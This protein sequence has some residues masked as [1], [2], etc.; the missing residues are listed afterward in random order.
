MNSSHRHKNSPARLYALITLC[1]GFLLGPAGSAPASTCIGSHYEATPPYL[2]T[3]IKPNV[4]L[5]LDNSGSMKDA[6]YTAAYD[7]TKTYSGI[8]D[9]TKNYKY[10]TTIAVNTTPYSGTP[11][12]V[13]VDTNAKGA[14]LEDS[15]CVLGT[16]TNC[17]KGNFL[18]WL[19]TR[20]IDAARKVLVGGKTESR[21]GY[22]Y[23]GGD[24]SDLEWKIVANNERSDGTISKSNAASYSYTPY[25]N[26]TG[27]SIQSP[28]ENGT[29]QTSY[30]PYAKLVAPT[31]IANS[32]GT[33]IGEAG[34]A[35]S[36]N[37]S[38]KTITLGRTYA[39]PIVVAKPISYDGA[40]P[41]VVRI[42]NVTA[43]SFQVMVKE[44]DYLDQG[45]T[46]E[47]IDYIVLEAGT[48]TLTNGKVRAGA[49]TANSNFATITHNAG[50]TNPPVVISS[51]TTVNEADTVTTRHQNVG[52]NSF[53]L[54][55]QEQQSKGAHGNETVHY[56]AMST[57]TP[58]IGGGTAEVKTV[59]NVTEAWKSVTFTTPASGMLFLAD[60]Q[61]YGDSDPASLRY[62]NLG[63]ASVE[64]FVEE[65]K[66]S[67]T[68]INHGNETVGVI[69]IKPATLNL[70]LIVEAEPTGLV[71]ENANEVRF[72]VSMYRYQRDTDIYNGEWAQGGTMRLPIPYNPFVKDAANTTFRTI[73]TPVKAATATIVDAIEHYPLVWG[74]TPLAENY[75]EVI[76]YFQQATPYYDNLPAIGTEDYL[77]W[78]SS[79]NDPGNLWDPFYYT[80][81][82]SKVRC[83]K[84][85]VIIFTDGEP[86]RDDYIP[87]SFVDYDG[88]LK[89]TDCSNTGNTSNVCP[90]NLDDVAY[91]AYWDKANTRTRDLRSDLSGEQYL[92]TYT[93][94][95]GSA[96]IP[97]ILQDTATNGHGI[98]YAAED[99]DQLADAL[100]AAITDILKKTASGSAIS[101]LSERAASGSVVHQ[102][103]FFPEKTFNT[104]YTLQWPGT[105]NA[106][107]FYNSRTA[108]NIREDNANN[109]FLDTLADNVLD[110]SIDT[111]S[112]NLQI[113]YYGTTSQ[114]AKDTGN[115]IGTYT[116]ID[117]VH[118]IWEGGEKLKNR[119]GSDRTIYGINES[120]TLSAFTAA[121]VTLFDGLFGD[122][123]KFPTCLGDA[124]NRATNL[125]GYTRGESDNFTSATGSACRTRVVDDDGHIWKLGDI[126]NSTPRLIDYTQYSVLFTGA[127]D[128][129]LHAFQVG[130][131]RKDGLAVNQA[132][133]LCDR[134]TGTCTT[135]DVGKELW[136]FIPKN[137]M[138]YLKYLTDPNFCHLYTVDLQTYYI[139]DGDQK[140]LIGGM[141]FGG[142]TAATKSGDWA[143]DDDT[144]KDGIID[145]ASDGSPMQIIPEAVGG[146]ASTTPQ[147]CQ[148]LSSY[149]ALDVTD[150]TNPIFLWEF[151]NPG[152]GFSYSGPAW[153]KRG[154]KRY[155]MFGSGPTNYRGEA[156]NQ[157]VKLFILEVDSNFR[158]VD[159][160]NDG[161]TL[162]HVHKIHGANDADDPAGGN[163][164]VKASDITN[165]NDSFIGRMFTD[166]VD[167]N[168]DGKTDV[169]YFGI[170]WYTGNEW[171]GNVVGVYPN[172][173]LPTDGIGTRN[174][175][176]KTVFNSGQ[177]PIT[178][179][180]ISGECFGTPYIYYGT[181]RWFYKLDTPGAL[182]GSDTNS[183]YGIA[184][185]DCKTAILA[186]ETNLDNKCGNFQASHSSHIDECPDAS[187]GNTAWQLPALLPNDGTYMKERLISDPSFSDN[188]IFFTTAQPS[189][190]LCA[191]GGQS[192]I[193]ALNCASGD[194][195][196]SQNCPGYIVS[197]PAA[198]LLLQLSGGNI[199]DTQLNTTSLSE[200]GNK[201]T[202][203]FVGMPPESGATFLPP[204]GLRKGKMILWIE[205]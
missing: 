201:A 116:S 8:F 190:D 60:I 6:M 164:F 32:V 155:V 146:C 58:T 63:S 159:S 141:R 136:S 178:A 187:P 121:N 188:M 102:A 78:D 169:V 42:Q 39:S 192:R 111:S 40:D 14:F 151:T 149:F 147:N 19:T 127:N 65:E 28:A 64:V 74:T 56:I 204:A 156:L 113:D 51:V 59:S 109:F 93:V 203:W 83:A 25:P 91:W 4:M 144:P 33:V 133:R 38:W 148:G 5:M 114:G 52:A 157:D 183:L 184:M 47:D 182:N 76:R 92:T 199:E 15:T 160:D 125:I 126:I 43:T 205:R 44:W 27:F 72:G 1:C 22:D 115:K 36:V 161:N 175:E 189:A 177:E 153:I 200:A 2:T 99:G 54:K 108:Q 46:T 85:F 107:W 158:M 180:V 152:L 143:G 129:M 88:D 26:N 167:F 98:A 3:R 110:F 95:F 179:K 119:A 124:A 145:L 163:R 122:T 139:N 134:N 165:L 193:F 128:G 13:T 150:P 29:T 138:P 154:T 130:K 185:G 104:T 191:F 31:F 174:W 7:N 53:D 41:S 23:V 75:H 120:N 123:T 70:A 61:T 35:S 117:D 202:S 103:L 57:G 142:A 96:T 77:V 106:Y 166:G 81:N 48:H 21:T 173:S 55:L 186:G 118:K 79:D 140:I 20:R 181:G 45:H 176:V 101:V 137:A 73:D 68:D 162:E 105:L 94:A 37:N 11:Y 87:A 170:N 172:D 66:S 89:G 17:W 100:T 196:F 71:Q 195:I 80:E 198:S 84:S 9:S 12:N 18:N 69:A 90:D 10:D 67:S 112:G 34:R 135:G 171:K 62:R 97:Q 82:S 86:Y 131:I 16:G 30:D 197:I 24:S 49:V 50:L 132:V 194:D 168:K